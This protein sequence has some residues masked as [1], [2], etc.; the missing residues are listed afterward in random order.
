M[1]QAKKKTPDNNVLKPAGRRGT[2]FKAK[3]GQWYKQRH[4]HKQN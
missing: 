4:I 1:S 3:E 2:L